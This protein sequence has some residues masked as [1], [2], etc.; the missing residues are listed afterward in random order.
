MHGGRVDQ[1]I[2]YL[3]QKETNRSERFDS[4][5]LASASADFGLRESAAKAILAEF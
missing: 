4:A 1:T 5:Y 3:F 2:E